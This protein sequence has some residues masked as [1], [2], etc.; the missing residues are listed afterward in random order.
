MCRKV[1]AQVFANLFS[2]GHI[3][4]LMVLI[5]NM[6]TDVFTNMFKNMLANSEECGVAW[7]SGA[8]A[9]WGAFL[10]PGFIIY[11]YERIDLMPDLLKDEI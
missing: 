3:H 10:M 4:P 1:D 8:M 9:P 7:T 6:S 11:Q 2:K 5:T